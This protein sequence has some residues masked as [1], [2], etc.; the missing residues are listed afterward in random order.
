MR[1]LLSAAVALFAPF[2]HATTAAVCG[3]KTI[4][5]QQAA[6]IPSGANLWLACRDSRQ[7]VELSKNGAPVRTVKL[8]QF[9]PWALVA[10]GGSVWAISRETP[11]LQRFDPRSGRR[12]AR[13]ALDSLPTSAWYGA[14]GV[15]LGFDGIGFARVDAK[16]GAVKSWTFG[17]GV[18]GFATDGTSVYAVSH[19]DNAITRV[20]ISTGRAS[21][22]AHDLA[23]TSTSATEEVAY[24]AGSL[25]ITGRGLD[26]LRVSATTGKLRATVEIGPAGLNVMTLAK[27]LLVATYSARGARRGDPIVGSFLTVD[28]TTNRVVARTNATATSYLSGLAL[29]GGSIYAADTVQGRL[30]RL[31]LP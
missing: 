1:L 2:P 22:L 20:T 21:T 16:T 27:R 28:P 17:D 14:G 18:S 23:D 29:A 15:W 9:R 31:A 26:L 13:I 25:W 4:P 12:V 8:G 5:F 6:L 11:E 24:T 10:G 19:R 7:L 3:A 30:A